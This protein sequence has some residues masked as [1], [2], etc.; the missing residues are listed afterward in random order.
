MFSSSHPHLIRQLSCLSFLLFWGTLSSVYAEEESNV[1]VLKWRN[2]DELSGGLVTGD[3]SSIRWE[4]SPFASPLEI[5]YSQ[6][7]GIRFATEEKSGKRPPFRLLLNNG[8]RLEGHLES[9]NGD[10]IT[11]RAL[12]FRES[13]QVARK[14]V[15][16]LVH[17][18][19]E[20]L[21]YSGP[22]ELSDW[23]SSGRDRKVSEWFTDLSGAFSTHQWS[24]NLFREIEFPNTVEI[25]FEAA[26]PRGF[27]SLEIGLVRGTDIGPMLETWDDSLVL[28]Y[29]SAFVPIM[30]L[31]EDTRRLDFRL[32]WNQTSGE[33]LLCDPSGRELASLDNVLVDRR[34]P[35]S[36]KSRQSDPLVRGVSIVNRTP[37]LKLLSLSVQEWDGRQPA[38][39]DLDRPR[40]L[41]AGQSPRFDVSGIRYSSESENFRIGSRQYP[42]EELQELILGSSR[43]AEDLV[44]RKSSTRMAWQ[45]GSNVSGKLESLGFGETTLLAEWSREP[46]QLKLDAAKE[47][48][49]PEP[50]NAIIAGSDVLSGEGFELHG[51]AQAL[52]SNEGPSLI[53]WLPPGATDPVPFAEGIEAKVTR[54]PHATS[55]P[56]LTSVIGQARLHL[57]N[58]EVLVG[59]LV[60]VDEEEIRFKSRIT[61]DITL[62]SNQLSA[63]DLGSSGR[64]LEGFEDPEWEIVDA[65]ADSVELSR[66]TEVLRAGGFGNPSLILGDRIHFSAKW[67]QTYGAVTLRLFTQGSDENSPSTDLIVA[68][69]GNRLFVGKLKE[70]G[71]FSFS[72]DQIPMV[73]DSASFEMRLLGDK[74]EVIVNGK[75]R[76]DISVDSDRVS[77][78]GIYFKMGGGWQGWN[79]NENEITITDFRV[80]RTPGSLPR[81]IIDPLAK[82]ISLN[83][84]R[85]RRDPVPTH[86]LIAPNGD[87]LRGNLKKASASGI[88]FEAGE[89]E[90]DLPTDRVSAI[91]WLQEEEET[92]EESS[93]GGTG[94][95]E[96]FDSE[97]LVTHQFVLMDGSRLNLFSEDLKDERFVGKSSLLG[98]CSIA[99]DNVREMKR[100]PA[101]PMK[102]LETLNDGVYAKWVLNPTPEP[103]IPGSTEVVTSPLVGEKAPEFE[104]TMLDE[105][106]FKLS[107]Y[108]GKVVVLDFWATW[109]GP[110]IKA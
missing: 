13:I 49:F 37:E 94:A 40:L 45:D 15:S 2:G 98:T 1:S 72:G 19:S 8:D 34:S 18:G 78:N 35:K 41:L 110:C 12:P 107:D 25:Q 3:N 57:V 109:C 6:L 58:G 7:D 16:R 101:T 5:S 96:V 42:L 50:E 54:F 60:S 21:R 73:G 22:S 90:I 26:F 55:N 56:S 61:G 100:G 88:R 69:Q 71:A 48:R 99:I 74:V 47:I 66:D 83:L 4:A 63:I 28:T 11:F 51:A 80:E 70:S 23:S 76:L 89:S 62:P 106:Q 79:Q 36:S 68:A 43:V 65:E 10:T 27:P 59:S 30:K 31:D 44:E 33:L 64:V 38:I 32:F 86:L 24:G 46:L 87:L 85:S 75:T 95:E 81:R 93:E 17:V 29:R 9:I 92:A 105:S 97:F 84:P 104:L 53:G 91:V 20:F 82:E 77:G 102:D 39:I 52:Q 103:A 108:S 67:K 14:H